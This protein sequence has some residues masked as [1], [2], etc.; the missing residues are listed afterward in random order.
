MGRVVFILGRVEG[1]TPLLFRESMKCSFGE[2]PW[3]LFGFDFVFWGL[4]FEGGC[5]LDEG[6]TPLL[7]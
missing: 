7:F 5:C 6:Q 4:G 2:E 1:Q 3:G